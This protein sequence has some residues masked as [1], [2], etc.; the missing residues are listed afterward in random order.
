MDRGKTQRGQTHRGVK[1]LDADRV[2]SGSK[3]TRDGP[4]RT[5][6]PPDTPAQTRQM[7]VNTRR[8]MQRGKR[9]TKKTLKRLVAA[10]KVKNF[11]TILFQTREIVFSQNTGHEG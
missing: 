11:S 4:Q 6:C 3:H 8:Q 9:G 2:T 10:E 5:R 7:S 1:D